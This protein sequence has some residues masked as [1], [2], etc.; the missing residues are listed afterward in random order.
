MNDKPPYYD[1]AGN[2][3]TAEESP[4]RTS[5]DRAIDEIVA[6]AKR[7]MAVDDKL[8][9]VFCLER[10]LQ[11]WLECERQRGLRRVL[12]V[13]D[14]VGSPQS[15]AVKSGPKPKWMQKRDELLKQSGGRPL[16][17]VGD[18][19]QI[20]REMTPD[21]VDT[22]ARLHREEYEHRHS[23]PAPGFNLREWVKTAK[24]GDRMLCE[25]YVRQRPQPMRFVRLEGFYLFFV[26]EQ[27][28]EHQFDID[29]AD[30]YRQVVPLPAD[31]S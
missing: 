17:G 13:T 7:L 2:E 24:P 11:I 16:T 28:V 12:P 5:F 26:N 31:K 22:F 8:N 30:K 18:F 3:Q 15:E 29:M 1:E 10:S 9:S 14:L 21:Q 4:A 6:G 19:D 23:G 25:N 27:G 20:I